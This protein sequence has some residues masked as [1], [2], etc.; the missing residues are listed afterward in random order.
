MYLFQYSSGWGYDPYETNKLIVTST[1]RFSQ[2]FKLNDAILRGYID[3]EIN[4]NGMYG[5]Y[6]Y[7]VYECFEEEAKKLCA[8]IVYEFSLNPIQ[9]FD[10]DRSYDPFILG[11][12]MAV[13]DPNLRHLDENCSCS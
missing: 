5:L 1:S 9:F 10:G 13:C 11:T 3:C 2:G 12:G 4:Q 7:N 6:L 8:N